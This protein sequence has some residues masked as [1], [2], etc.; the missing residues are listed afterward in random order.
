MTVTPDSIESLLGYSVDFVEVNGGWAP[1]WMNYNT[2]PPPV[3][4]TKEEAETLFL[5]FLQ[6]LVQTNPQSVQASSLPETDVDKS[7]LFR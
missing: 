7:K 6:R 5:E 2:S 3:G 4:K 1:E